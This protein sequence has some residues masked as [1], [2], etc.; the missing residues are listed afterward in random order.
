MNFLN[1]ALLVLCVSAFFP[2]CV[3]VK[4]LEMTSAEQIAISIA[5]SFV[6]SKYPDFDKS[7]KKVVISTSGDQW[8]VTYELPDDMLGGAPVVFIDKLTGKVTRSYRTQ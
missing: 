3:N 7:R 8:E 4:G 5:E 2:A 6:T 1:T